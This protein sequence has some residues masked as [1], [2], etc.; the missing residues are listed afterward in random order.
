MNE[1]ERAAWMASR[2][3]K[4]T[5]SRIADVLAKPLKGKQES[6]T[7]RNYRAELV[8]E[9]MTGRTQEGFQT[10]D[11]KRGTELEPFAR[12]EYELARGVMIENVAFIAHGRIPNTGASPDGLIGKDGLV[13]FKCP[14]TATH[15]DWLMA[16]IVP[17]EHR[18]QMLW[19]MACTGRQWCDFASYDPNLP[20]HLQLFIVRFDRDE[21]AIG[22]LEQEVEKFDAEIRD[23]IAN[24]PSQQ[25]LE[26][27]LAKSIEITKAK[28]TENA[29]YATEEDIRA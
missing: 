1:Q 12:T 4:I 18:P 7:R 16:G 22:E 20:Q 8:C 3:G 29:L 5:A 28:K 27:K 19:E 21:V 14:K 26:E 24:L 6:A 17:A 23:I 25:S 10:W 9:R 15:L 2:C 13:Q 11:M